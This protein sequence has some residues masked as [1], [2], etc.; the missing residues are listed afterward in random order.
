M[1][2]IGVKEFI[3]NR[4]IYGVGGGVNWIIK[5]QKKS[6]KSTLLAGKNKGKRRNHNQKLSN[7]LI[8]NTPSP[9]HFDELVA[10]EVRRVHVIGGGNRLAASVGNLK[11]YWV[12]N[13]L[14]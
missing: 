12:M 6:P 13:V 11:S 10:V 8:I 4:T 7:Y 9:T 2:H 1:K 3:T 14:A 5:K